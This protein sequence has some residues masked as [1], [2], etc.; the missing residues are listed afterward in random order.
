MKHYI[1]INIL[2]TVK[3]NVSI[4]YGKYMSYIERNLINEEFKAKQ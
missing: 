1:A 4:G 3:Q 2:C